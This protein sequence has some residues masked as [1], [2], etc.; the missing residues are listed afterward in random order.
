M[1]PVEELVRDYLRADT[2]VMTLL[3]NEPKR[4]DVEYK[5]PIKA[6]HVTLYRSGG[7]Q[8]D[9]TPLDVALV[10]LHAYGT[11]RRMAATLADEV[12][13]AMRTLTSMARPL[14]SASV[15]SLTYLP[16]GD[17][18][19]RYAVTASVTRTIDG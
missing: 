7:Y 6:T 11:T 1:T 19:A 5:G 12:A 2:G 15:E 3:D 8:T 13:R 18:T 9:Y 10:T 14:V 16:A 17:G 4:M